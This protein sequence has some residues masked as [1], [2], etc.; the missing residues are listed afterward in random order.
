M[1]TEEYGRIIAKNLKRIAYDSGK[2]QADIA[3]DLKISKQTLSS[4]M[5]GTR[6]PRMSK[7]DLLCSYFNCTR[8]DIMEYHADNF[9]FGGVLRRVSEEDVKILEAYRNA[10]DSIKDS[11]LILL[12]LKERG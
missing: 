5:T 11:V 9:Y 10:P 12:G 8:S 7:V 3:R 2:T 6:I 4:W 1:T